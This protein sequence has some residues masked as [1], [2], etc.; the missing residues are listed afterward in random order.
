MAPPRPHAV[1]VP[2]PGSGNINPALQ[3]AKLLHRGGVFVTFV[4]TEHNHRRIKASAAAALAGREDEDDGSFRF[5]AIPDGLAEADRAADAY[6]LGLSAATSHRC[7]APL[8]ELVARLNATAGVPRVTCLLTTALMGFA[9]DVAREL[10]VPSMVLW[11]GSAASLIGHMRLRELAQ[12]GY[13]PLK[14]SFATMTL[15]SC[16]SAMGAA[17]AGC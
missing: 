3:L 8:R 7:A 2:Y 6:D 5:E 4:N 16:Y 1:V 15:R 10:G 13:L 14:V 11:G 9:L 12:R 17:K